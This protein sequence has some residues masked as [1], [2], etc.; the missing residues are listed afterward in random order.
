MDFKVEL[1]TFACAKSQ[2]LARDFMKS[3]KLVPAK[4]SHSQ[5][6]KILY[7]Q[8]IV[9]IRYTYPQ[10]HMSKPAVLCSGRSLLCPGRVEKDSR[11]SWP[12]AGCLGVVRKFRSFLKY[13]FP[14][15]LLGLPPP[16]PPLTFVPK[17]VWWASQCIRVP[18]CTWTPIQALC[19]AARR[20]HY[21]S[22]LPPAWQLLTALC[23]SSSFSSNT[24][25]A[26]S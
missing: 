14:K 24:C 18:V 12:T 13:V 19:R 3:Q 21:P 2:N 26:F 23:L 1:F 16:P 9:T 4:S 17:R 22:P 7:S 5:N 15:N 11:D 20:L 8:I 6:R 10:I 25:D